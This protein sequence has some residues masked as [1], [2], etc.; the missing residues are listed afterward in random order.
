MG[1]R[2]GGKGREVRS[3]WEGRGVGRRCRGKGRDVRSMWEG[4]GGGKEVWR[5]GECRE[6]YVGRGRDRVAIVHRSSG[7]LVAEWL[8]HSTANRKVAGS[9]PTIA[10]GDFLSPRS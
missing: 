2:C 1:R 4:R 9:N 8:N 6:E 7:W 3:M 10:V 5:E